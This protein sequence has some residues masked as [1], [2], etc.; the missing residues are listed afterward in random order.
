MT[1]LL[2]EFEEGARRHEAERHGLP[3]GWRAAFGDRFTSHDRTE[4]RAVILDGH[5]RLLDNGAFGTTAVLGALKA[6]RGPFDWA[7][8]LRGE[9]VTVVSLE[10]GCVMV[11]RDPVGV[12]PL[13][14]TRAAGRVALST[15]IG[16]LLHLPW[17]SR[18]LD[19]QHLLENLANIYRSRS[20]TFYSRISTVPP[21]CVVAV[22]NGEVCEHRY[23]EWTFTEDD[24]TSFGDAAAQI[25]SAFLKACSPPWN[26]TEL[27]AEVSGGLD[28]SAVVGALVRNGL[29]PVV[30]RL[31][32]SDSR[33]D[34]RTYSDAVIAH[35]GVT[36]ISA[37]PWLPTPKQLHELMVDIATPLPPPNSYMA[38]NLHSSLRDYG[39]PVF[40]T[41]L[42]GDDAFAAAPIGTRAF[43]AVRHRQK[44]ELAIFGR[45]AL[46]NPRRVWPG[47]LRPFTLETLGRPSRHKTNVWLSSDSRRQ[48]DLDTT[49]RRPQSV[50]QFRARDERWHNVTHGILAGICETL[51]PILCRGGVRQWHPYLDVDFIE[52]SYRFRPAYARQ[53]GLDR[54]LQRASLGSFLPE[55][56]RERR[57]KAEF[58]HSARTVLDQCDLASVLT[59][60]LAK[61]GYLDLENVRNLFTSYEAG[62]GGAVIAVSNLYTTDQWLRFQNH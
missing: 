56:V 7:S 41:G 22:R 4:H 33:A 49:G 25:Q 6:A 15:S 1:E 14:I 9:F 42:G 43:D 57:S 39:Y 8:Q 52:A 23:H 50:G 30:G 19:E 44:S 60:P 38:S 24:E 34:E 29:S 17:V 48:Y 62:M 54:S 31:L 21:G 55:V 58:S 10:D 12:R 28:S 16:A 13:Y 26:Q 46:A 61:E 5:A 45:W 35:N 40:A 51:A 11:A 3:E 27:G 2:L 20:T 37:D 59:G 32:F 18:D 53:N 36:E 47:L